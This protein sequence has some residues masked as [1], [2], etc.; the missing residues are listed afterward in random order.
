MPELTVTSEIYKEYDYSTKKT[1][2]KEGS[3]YNT[4]TFYWD[5]YKKL[6]TQKYIREGLGMRL[7][8]DDFIAKSDIFHTN[9]T[10]IEL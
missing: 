2:S 7:S 8:K 5:H 10:T 6:Q 4:I 3:K 9:N 1:P